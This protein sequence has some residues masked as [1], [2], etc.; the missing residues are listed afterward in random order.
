M[1]SSSFSHF[2]V[3][4]ERVVHIIMVNIFG[5]DS[6]RG[7]DGI[8]G[9]AGVM[10]RPGSMGPSG[11]KGS[12][13]AVGPAGDRGAV[14]PA[15][16]R[17]RAGPMGSSVIT[18]LC[19]WMP[20]TVLEQLQ[21]IEEEGSFFLIDL[22]K[23][24]KRDKPGGSVT[25]WNTR[26]KSHRHLNLK[27]KHPSKNV[28]QLPNGCYALEFDNSL[29]YNEEM[30]DA[31]GYGFICITFRVRGGG[32]TLITN[33]DSDNLDEF[34]E[35]SATTS[36]I[37]ISGVENHEVEHI[38]IPHGCGN[39]T[40]LFVEWY[41]DLDENKKYGS[42]TINNGDATG[43]FT[44]DVLGLSATRVSVGGGGLAQSLK[45]DI[46]AI[47]I[48]NRTDMDKKQLPHVLKELIINN[49]MVKEQRKRKRCR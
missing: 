23:D 15:G 32:G 5:G 42:Y 43:H 8:R 13:G 3:A 21:T 1:L 25:E 16:A 30:F 37:C 12:A 2:W 40:T 41:T 18:D 24:I 31:I 14:G 26:S 39:W 49:Q 44:F 11:P 29:Y 28:I 7:K 6:V 20:N 45:G 19:S 47:E 33:Y 9:P 27:A 46:S 34:I 36:N 10:G 38:M 48:Y 17:G 4:F 22:A 35:I